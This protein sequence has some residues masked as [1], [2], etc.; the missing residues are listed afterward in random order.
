MWWLCFWRSVPYLLLAKDQVEHPLYP[1]SRK[2]YGKECEVSSMWSTGPNRDHKYSRQPWISGQPMHLQELCSSRKEFLMV[3]TQTWRRGSPFQDTSETCWTRTRFL[4]T[5][6]WGNI[7]RTFGEFHNSGTWKFTVHPNMPW[8]LHAWKHTSVT[9][10]LSMAHLLETPR[11]QT[12]RFLSSGRK[13]S[14]GC[15][16]GGGWG[17]H[18]S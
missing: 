16:W 2:C 10:P 17:E 7:I 12:L 5:K 15:V 1:W 14:F 11:A 6:S 3:V 4:S 13:C 18:A 9:Q 8:H